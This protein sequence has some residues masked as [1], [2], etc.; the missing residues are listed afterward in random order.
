MLENK[1]NNPDWSKPTEGAGRGTPLTGQPTQRQ[2]AKEEASQYGIDTKGMSTKEITAAVKS[3]EEERQMLDRDINNFVEKSLQQFIS[4]KKGA[5]LNATRPPA[6]PT[7]RI[8]ED[9]RSSLFAS[10]G[11][12]SGGAKGDSSQLYD[13]ASTL[14][15][16]CYV[17]GVAGYFE[18]IGDPVFKPN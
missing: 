5:E 11:A 15:F 3:Y 1:L 14:K 9:K 8:T 7:S 10:G 12:G 2:A 16:M 4:G 13:I 17:D 6:S 18:L